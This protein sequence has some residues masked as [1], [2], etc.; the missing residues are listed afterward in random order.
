M[1]WQG[2]LETPRTLVPL[3]RLDIPAGWLTCGL[4]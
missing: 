3:D 2:L 1:L 4:A